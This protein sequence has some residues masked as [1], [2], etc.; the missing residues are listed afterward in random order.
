MQQ[1]RCSQPER[2]RCCQ[3]KEGTGLENRLVGVNRQSQWEG[4]ELPPKTPEIGGIE[5]MFIKTEC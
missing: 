3:S 2:V 1:S 5:W 4:G